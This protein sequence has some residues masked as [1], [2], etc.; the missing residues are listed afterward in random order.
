MKIVTSSKSGMSSFLAKQLYGRATII[1]RLSSYLLIAPLVLVMLMFFGIPLG[2][3]M[4][5]SFMDFDGFSTIR[6]FTWLNYTEFFE[7]SLTWKLYYQTFRTALIVWLICLG[8]ALT[9]SNFLVFHVKS[10]MVQIGLLLLCTIPFWTSSI[11]RMISWLPVLGRHGLINSS[12]MSVGIIDEPIDDLIYS[13]LAVVIVYVQSFSLFMIVPI[14]NSMVR[15]S[16]DI[17]EA[18]KEAGASR[19]Q[20]LTNIVIP[21]SKSGIALG[22]I[23]IIAL[24]MGDF[25]IIRVMGGGQSSNVAMAISNQIG[26]FQYPPAAAASIIFLCVILLIISAMLRVVDVRKEVLS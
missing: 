4:V 1:N 13:N 19:W 7:S 11:I 18:A 25:F 8:I 3:I 6:E 21:L 2:A 17:V 26:S 22:T 24:V 10:L 12:L 16:P 14:F 20:V 5:V 15:I 9:V 23:F